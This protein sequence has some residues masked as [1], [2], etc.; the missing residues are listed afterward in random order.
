MDHN[1]N[2]I[3]V[4][5]LTTQAGRS[6]TFANW[7][8]VDIKNVALDLSALLVKPGFEFLKNLSSLASYMGWDG[9]I[10]LNAS[11][12][13]R[14]VQ[15]GYF[16]R[17]EYDGSRRHY[18]FNDILS[19]IVK[20]KP[21]GVL[22]PEGFHEQD[23]T[24]WLSL[25]SNTLPF[26]HPKDIHACSEQRPYGVYFILEDGES[27]TIVQQKIEA[28]KDI[29]CLIIGDLN[30]AVFQQLTALGV[31]YLASD[32]PALDACQGVV[33]SSK[34]QLALTDDN[35]RSDF[36]VID[37]HCSCPTCIQKLTRAYLCHLF[38]H[39]PLLCQRFLIQHNIYFMN[40]LAF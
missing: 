25:S 12:L 14:N 31:R 11:F 33:Y 10:I 24:A 7:H 9:N 23:K 28:L 6:L 2:G 15:D 30:L 8:E 1:M 5:L 34:G 38:E 37:E 20:L 19:L 16:V 18:S 3:F 40:H 17:S 39:T 27:L 22:L 21:T 35:I 29:P 13:N 26:F 36:R 32:R 4:P